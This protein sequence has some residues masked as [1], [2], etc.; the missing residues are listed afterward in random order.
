MDWRS[1]LSSFEEHEPSGS[2]FLII[3]ELRLPFPF[4]I[5]NNYQTETE[6]SSVNSILMAI[7]QAPV[8]RL[9]YTEPETIEMEY[10]HIENFNG[11]DLTLSLIHI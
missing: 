5:M 2:Y 9:Y 11:K 4:A 1:R 10:R 8:T 6:L 3:W 7:G